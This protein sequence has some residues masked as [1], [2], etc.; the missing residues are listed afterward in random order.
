M[1]GMAGLGGLGR[2]RPDQG[3]SPT[4]APMAPGA[5][6]GILRAREVIIFG[7]GPALLVYLPKPGPGNLV[8]SIAAAAFA[9]SS[10]NQVEP[11]VVSYPGVPGGA[12]VQ[13]I[14]GFLRFLV[15]GVSSSAAQISAG[16]TATGAE[17]VIAS[18]AGGQGGSITEAVL[19]LKDSGQA[20][21]KPVVETDNAALLATSL[22]VPLGF[23]DAAVPAGAETWAPVTPLNGW[24]VTAPGP[25]FSARRIASPPN[26]LQVALDLTGGIIANN[27][28]IAAGLPAPKHTQSWELMCLGATASPTSTPRLQLDTGGGLSLTSVPAGVT[29][30]RANAF[31]QLDL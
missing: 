22:Y 26:T 7:T 19:S 31:Y 30:I 15:P 21:G 29:E 1:A 2:R 10:G 9:D 5:G 8:D 6:A 24:S 28:P 16:A 25:G 4:G 18:G 3:Y 14:Q 27:T 20:A 12:L 17:M 23:F 11:G 13:L